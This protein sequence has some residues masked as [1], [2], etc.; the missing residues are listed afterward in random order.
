MTVQGVLPYYYNTP[1]LTTPGRTK[2]LDRCIY[3][4]MADVP[5]CLVQ[6][7][8]EIKSAHFTICQKPWI[9][10]RKYF[11]NDLCKALHKRWF[12]LRR[13]AEDF[14]EVPVTHVPCPKGGHDGYIPMQ[15]DN[16]AFPKYAD[17]FTQDTSI[18]FMPP[19]PGSGFEDGIYW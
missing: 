4:T 19:L 13:E 10:L 1:A 9:C 11:P 6:T 5:E 17:K 18:G 14:Y 7:L 2:I 3:N 16:A 8:Q 15:L 12:D